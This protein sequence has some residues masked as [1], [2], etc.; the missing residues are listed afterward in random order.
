MR[1]FLRSC[2]ADR[3]DKSA[4]RCRL[5]LEAREQ[6]LPLLGDPHVPASRLR[7][8]LAVPLDPR[9]ELA[10]GEAVLGLKQQV[11]RPPGVLQER[12]PSQAERLVDLLRQVAQVID[13]LGLAREI[14]ASVM[15]GNPGS[16]I[17]SRRDCSGAPLVRMAD[18]HAIVGGSRMAQTGRLV[19]RVEAAARGSGL[20]RTGRVVWISVGRHCSL[21]VGME[22]DR[23]RGRGP[24][25]CAGSPP[26]LG[27]R[28]SPGRVDDDLGLRSGSD[29]HA[30]EHP[31]GTVG[32]ATACGNGH[33][34]GR[35]RHV[36]AQSFT[37]SLKCIQRCAQSPSHA[38][39]LQLDA[40]MPPLC[41]AI[42]G[43]RLGARATSTWREKPGG[44]GQSEEWCGLQV[45]HIRSP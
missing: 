23:C 1:P 27:V 12:P 39:R 15:A 20:T 14:R 38:E 34:G 10:V 17:E 18:G 31:F 35:R 5:L 11:A 22:R 24:R 21:Q 36:H 8:E 30:V 26:S 7:A 19:G 32:G 44:I 42:Q 45:E 33:R 6:G 25:P 43:G 13:D 4:T 2:K 29:A 37:E 40:A 3:R 41:P 16:V 28:A 9:G